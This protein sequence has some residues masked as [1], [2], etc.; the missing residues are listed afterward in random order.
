MEKETVTFRIAAEKKEALDAVA[1]GLE[2]DRSY[3]LNQAVDNYLDLH[4]WQ[5][6]HIKNALRQAR[7]GKG[8]A[9]DQ[10][11]AALR[12][13]S[14]RHAL[15]NTGEFGGLGRKADGTPWTVGI[16]HPRRPD[17]YIATRIVKPRLKSH[18]AM[19]TSSQRATTLTQRAMLDLIRDVTARMFADATVSGSK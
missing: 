11:E 15:V 14:I 9:S 3:I 18:L 7:A 6:E 19:A 4:R 10:V 13:R 2:R 1:A 5:V 12:A 8:F 16:Q 17:A